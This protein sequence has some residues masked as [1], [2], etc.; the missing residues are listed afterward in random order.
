MSILVIIFIL[1]FNTKEM[2][3]ITTLLFP[4]SVD[5]ISFLDDIESAV[6]IDDKVRKEEIFLNN[7][8]DIPNFINKLENNQDYIVS[9]AFVRDL[10]NFS[11]HHP[12]MILSRSVLVNKFSSP[13]TITKFIDE[14]LN[15]MIECYHLDDSI[16]QDTI[17]GPGII[18]Y[19]C[20]FK[21]K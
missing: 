9:I 6:I 11:K 1:Y 17:L 2:S 16:F 12:Q 20:K 13:T 7:T 14:R 18:L 4:L 3:I 10:I 5:K 21:V 15:F 8:E 19:Y